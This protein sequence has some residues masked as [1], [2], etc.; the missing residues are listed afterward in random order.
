MLACSRVGVSFRAESGCKR[1]EHRRWR[2]DQKGPE[3]GDN[4]EG[5]HDGAPQ[6]QLRQVQSEKD[7]LSSMNAPHKNKGMISI[8]LTAQ[9]NHPYPIREKVFGARPASRT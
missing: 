5:A 2:S 9:W 6:E 7:H 3:D 4:G 8:R 1:Q